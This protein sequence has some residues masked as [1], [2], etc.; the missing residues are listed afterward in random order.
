[1]YA[2][3]EDK[4]GNPRFT[5]EQAEEFKQC[6]KMMMDWMDRNT[7]P[8]C[9]CIITVRDCELLDGVMGVVNKK[10]ANPNNTDAV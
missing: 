3:T 9:T 1:M 10:Y 8:H 4:D 5:K 7:H 2:G 6:S